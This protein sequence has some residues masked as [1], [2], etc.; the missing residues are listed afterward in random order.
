MDE[1]SHG[2]IRSSRNSWV[3]AMYMSRHLRTSNFLPAPF[4][5][6]IAIQSILLAVIKR[7]PNTIARDGQQRKAHSPGESYWE[8]YIHPPH[9]LD[10]QNQISNF[11]PPHFPF[12]CP[13]WREVGHNLLQIMWHQAHKGGREKGISTKGWNF[14]LGKFRKES[15]RKWQQPCQELK[16]KES[17]FSPWAKC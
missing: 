7:L 17:G 4:H 12:L 9:T 5:L 14:S 6:G 8:M 3:F 15:D 1:K 13:Q 16:E 2:H 10:L 11:S